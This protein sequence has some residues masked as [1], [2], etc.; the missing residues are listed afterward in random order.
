MLPKEE[1]AIK[2]ETQVPPYGLGLER[3][4]FAIRGES[5]VDSRVGEPLRTGEMKRFG[6]V[7]FKDKPE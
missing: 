1:L 5:Q 3:S 7:V 2:E 4:S 6:L